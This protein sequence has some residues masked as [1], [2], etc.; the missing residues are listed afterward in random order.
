MSEQKSFLQSPLANK[1]VVDRILDRIVNAIISGELKPGDKIPTEVELC[2]SLQVG[3]NSVREAVKVLVSFGVVQIKR[4]EGTFVCETFDHRMLDPLLYGLI[5]QRDE[6]GSSLVEL[7]QI[8]DVGILQ[9]VTRKATQKDI[10]NIR[11]ALVVLDREI[12]DPDTQAR[13]SLD[14][15]IQFHWAIAQALHNDLV[16]SVASY[17][18]RMT[19]PSRTRTHEEILRSGGRQKFSDLHHEILSTIE[20]KDL[21]S[22]GQ[23][24]ED[25]YTFWRGMV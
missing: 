5:L 9:L 13:R 12:M 19:I 20:R 15:D 25:H 4:S 23:V 8:F 2:E 16:L 7:R 24:V 11:R 6:N 21:S 18:D 14:A 1:S 10:D 22:I 17:I 3:R